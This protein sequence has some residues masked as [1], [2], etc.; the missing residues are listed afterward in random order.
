MIS[1]GS[2]TLKNV[3][4]T[5]GITGASLARGHRLQCAFGVQ[6]VRRTVR[7]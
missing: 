7:F 1:D 6:G 5:L 2:S 3:C 4:D